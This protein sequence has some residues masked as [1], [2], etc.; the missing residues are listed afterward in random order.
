MR[1]RHAAGFD[2]RIPAPEPVARE[3]KVAPGHF[4]DAASQT[5]A[6]ARVEARE[7]GH[8]RVAPEHVLLALT[9]DGDSAAAR[10]LEHLGTSAATV[11]A[12]IRRVVGPGVCG[13]DRL[14]HLTPRARLVVD[15]AVRF[16]RRLDTGTAGIE[17]LLYGVAAERESLAAKILRSH[18]ITPGHIERRIMMLLDSAL[19]DM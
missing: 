11:H 4:D 16:A 5:V 10:I 9:D 13:N 3:S 15:I 14:L 18:G 8:H 19:K 1:K 12:E 17:H 2:S 7:F 6:L